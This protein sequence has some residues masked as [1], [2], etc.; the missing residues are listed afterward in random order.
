MIRDIEEFKAQLERQ[1]FLNDCPLRDAKIGVGDSGTV[2]ELA[3]G[4]AKCPEW[5][6][7]ECIREEERVRTIGSRLPGILSLEGPDLV[8]NISVGNTTC[9]GLIIGLSD[10]NRE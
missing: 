6:R 4:V 3:I 7:C 9:Q 1:R 10:R 2:E 5:A 8:G